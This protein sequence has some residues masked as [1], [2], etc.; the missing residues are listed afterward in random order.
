[1]SNL[2]SLTEQDKKTNNDFEK[3]FSLPEY[4]YTLY[5]KSPEQLGMSSEGS[6]D[7]LGKDITGLILGIV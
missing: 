2:D 7:V 3:D 6:L 1:M 5:V 4:N